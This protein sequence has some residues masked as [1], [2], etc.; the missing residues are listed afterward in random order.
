MK[1]VQ[2]PVNTEQNATSRPWGWRLFRLPF[3]GQPKKEAKAG[4]LG[5]RTSEPSPA[6]TRNRSFQRMAASKR[7]WYR[8]CNRSQRAR[9]NRSGNFLRAWQKA[10]SLTQLAGRW[11]QAA[12][13]QSQAR[14]SPWVID[15]VCSPT[16]AMS[17][18]T[19]CGVRG[20]SFLGAQ[21]VLRAIV[22]KSPGVKTAW[23]RARPTERMVPE[24]AWVEPMNDIRSLRA[25]ATGWAVIHDHPLH[26]IHRFTEA[27]FIGE[28]GL[29]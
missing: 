8:T 6:S 21:P 18:K 13:T 10:S 4:T 9:Q 28:M 14:R 24:R 22:L 7:S 15:S 27:V 17:Q 2:K 19:T 20:R 25:Q 12:R 16:Q 26:P 23:N 1:A 11:G 5:S 29:A 3:L